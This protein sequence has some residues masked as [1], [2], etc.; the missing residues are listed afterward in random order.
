MSERTFIGDFKRNF[1]TGFAALFP[2]LITVFLLS[3][4]YI[5]LDRTVGTAVNQVFRTVLAEQPELFDLVF[6]NAPPEVVRDPQRRAEYVQ[7]FPRFVG[8]SIGIVVALVLIYLIGIALRSYLGARAISAVDHF[9][10]RFPVIKAIYPHARQ[11]ADLLF[12]GHNR[13]GFRHVVAVQYPRR[14]MHTIGF[15]TGEGLKDVQDRA[16]KHL[17]TV[18]VPTSPAPLTGFIVQV[19]REEVTDVSM[20]VEEALRFCMTAGM[21]ASPAQRPG[22]QGERSGSMLRLPPPQ[23]AEEE[24]ES[25]LR[26]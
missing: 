4:L 7:R 13:M 26:Q 19:S 23:A 5:Q 14:G 12:G 16:G 9:F 18:F 3:W 8:V 22:R 1:L 21:V 24:A 25:S 2:V 20:S 15:L 6:P 17:V 11:V 10:E